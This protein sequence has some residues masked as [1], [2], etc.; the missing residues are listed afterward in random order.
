MEVEVL[1]VLELGARGREQLLADLDVVVHRAADVEEQ[2]HLHRVVPLRHHLDVEPAGV[3]RGR[4]DG[5]VEVELLGRAF[6]REPAQAPQ[7]DLDVARAEFDRVVEVAV[8]ALVPDLH[9][10]AVARTRPGRCARL[11]GC[12][13]RRRRARCRAVPIHFEPPWCRP[14]CSSRR[15]RS[16]SMSLSQPPRTRSAV[17]SSSVSISS[18]CFLS[19]SSGMLREEAVGQF[20]DALEV[21]GEHAVEAVVVRSRPSPA[22]RGTGSRSLRR[23]SRRRPSPAPRSASGTP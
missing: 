3:A 1:Q 8:L 11:R 16:V 6:A 4:A 2:Q 12:S 10:A 5:V 14:F 23:D 21:G 15:L 20:G 18:A 17:L 9:R 13:R 22:R 19:H 7:R